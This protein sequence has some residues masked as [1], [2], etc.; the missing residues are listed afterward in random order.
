MNWLEAL[1][2]GIVQGLTEFLPVS[3][4]GHLELGKVLLGVDAERSLIFTVV[5]HGATVLSTIVI[6]YKDIWALIKG[7]FQFKWNEETQYAAKI[8]IS[9]IPV[10]ILGL[11][12]AEEI[13]GFFT[14]NMDF[15]G[16]MLIVTSLLL[17]F[18][19][20]SKSNKRP[21]GFLDSLIIG[22]MQALAVLPGISR[23]GSTIAG[24]ILLGNKKETIA[25]FSFL[26]VLI[27]I[28][29]ANVKDL[30]DGNL[31]QDSNISPLV[32]LIG[33]VAAFISGA[34]ACKWMINIVKKGKLIYF[35]VYCFIVG[36]VA[37]LFL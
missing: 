32:L 33:F 3:S 29:G 22:T 25:K 6:F 17:A 11:F 18:T 14:G 27:P 20:F 13:Q 1:I 7:I 34:L 19:Y 24:G 36:L 12:Y 5:V 30:M 21:V 10:V 8:I 35:S 28:I 26:M 2:L 31:S 15:V 37:I 16:S 23:S 9:M 4:S